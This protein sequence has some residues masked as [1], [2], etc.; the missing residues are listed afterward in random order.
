[1]IFNG[2]EGLK[3]FVRVK[4]NQLIDEFEKSNNTDEA[5]FAKGRFNAY[6]DVMDLIDAFEK[7][8]EEVA[9][10]EDKA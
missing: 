10:E 2:L 1:M 4:M 5:M 3:Y 7:A 6:K 9:I 8:N